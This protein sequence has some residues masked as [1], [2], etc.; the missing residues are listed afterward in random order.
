MKVL[1]FSNTPALGAEFINKDARLVGTG[2]WLNALNR[3]MSDKVELHI[4]FH[5]PYKLHN[6]TYNNTQYHPISVGNFYVKIILNRFLSRIADTN[7]LNRYLGIINEVK[8]D[9]IHIHGTENSF[10]CLLKQTEVPIIVSIQGNLTVLNHKYN[11]GFLGRYLY[12]I[13]SYKFKDQ[14]IGLTYFKKSK[15]IISKMAYIEQARMKDIEFIIGRTD[16]DYRI[17][18][19]LALN[20]LYFK[21]D[22]LLRDSFYNFVWN[23]S[24]FSGKLV[25]FTT[26][27][28]SYYKGLETVF[29]SISLLMKIGIDIE[30]RIAGVQ[31]GSLITKICRKFLGANFPKEGYKLLGSID[32]ENLVKELL[33]SHIYVMPSHIE[34]SPNNLCE[35]MILGMPCIAT[36]AG[37][38]GSILKD[39]EEGILIQDADPFAMAGAVVE[40]IRRPTE[41]RELGRKARMR[42]LLRHNHSRILDQYVNIYEK[43][44]SNKKFGN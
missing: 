20:S 44:I 36:F 26:N 23:N 41:A 14:L 43:T 10:L 32:E 30:W 39:G 22:E 17:S 12:V 42:A 16:W 11:S 29:H 21:G 6:F 8:P 19:I 28:D 3:I 24:Y 31:E 7:Y 2:G 1:W 25:V 37:G 33:N 9:L 15:S 40:L 13:K 5:Y 18:R 34:N 35:A 4:A 38:T 27:G